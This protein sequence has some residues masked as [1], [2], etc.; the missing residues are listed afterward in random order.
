M[1]FYFLSALLVVGSC[2]NL[3]HTEKIKQLKNSIVF[4]DASIINKYSN[5][6]NTKDLRA[7]LSLF[8]SDSLNGR[9]TGSEGHN[10]ASNYLRSYYKTQNINSPEGITDYYQKIPASY[11]PEDIMNSSQNVIAFIEGSVYPEEVLIISGHLDHIGVIEGAIY[12][13]AD[14]NGSGNSAILEIAQAFKLAAQDGYRPKRSIAF[15]HMTAEELGLEGSRYYVENPVFPLV[16]TIANLNI[17]MIGR[18]DNKYQNNEDYIYL[19][20]SDRLSTEL[21]YISERANEEFTKLDIDYIYNEEDDFNR[22][23]YRSDHYNFALE[24]IPVIF[25]FNGE[26][27]DYHQPTDTI[28]KIDF[29]LLAKRAKLIFSTAWYLANADERPEVDKF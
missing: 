6:I 25:Y 9:M 11:F 15:I 26:H 16:N 19:I 3:R 29:N 23:Y 21:H 5:T 22:Y 2:T 4:E 18:R 27:D 17:D 24:G 10:K 20:G 8:A 7:H 13:G 14:D 12:N 1:K 28:E